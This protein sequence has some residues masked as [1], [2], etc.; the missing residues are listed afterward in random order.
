[1]CVVMHMRGPVADMRCPDMGEGRPTPHT[2]VLHATCV[3]SG[4]KEATADERGAVCQG[5][6]EGLESRGY[7]TV[8]LE[9]C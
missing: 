6:V 5:V 1:M 8:D 2:A 9:S 4:I 7:L 3:D